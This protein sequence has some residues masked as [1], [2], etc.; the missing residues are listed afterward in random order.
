MALFKSNDGFEDSSST[1]FD[2][3]KPDRHRMNKLKKIVD[4]N[5]R[6]ERLKEIKEREK[7]KREE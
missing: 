7:L 4:K 2:E 5:R 3:P 1:D 6:K